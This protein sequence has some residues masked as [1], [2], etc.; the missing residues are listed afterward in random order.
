MYEH[1]VDR[2]R[3]MYGFMIELIEMSQHEKPYV[4]K[5]MNYK[6]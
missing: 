5:G 1:V 3:F 2:N 4:E 6:K